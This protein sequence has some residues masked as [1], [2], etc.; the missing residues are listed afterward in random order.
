MPLT[1]YNMVKPTKAHRFL[2]HILLIMGNFQIELDL[3]RS[4]N[5]KKYL[6][7]ISE[8]NSLI[9]KSSSNVSDMYVITSCI[10]GYRIR[11]TL[12]VPSTYDV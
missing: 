5:L 7:Y 9:E 6:V 12:F 3:F 2:I 11:I 1:I 8:N 4:H 10:A